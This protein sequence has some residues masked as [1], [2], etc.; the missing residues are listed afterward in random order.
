MPDPLPCSIWKDIILDKYID[1]E[2]LYAGMD[3]GY[4]HDDEPRDFRG[5]YSIVK[6]DHYC[7]NKPIQSE[8]EWIRVARAWRQG[9]ELLYPHR[10]SEFATYME[11]IEELFR[12]APCTPLVAIGVDVEARDRYAKHPYRMDD[13]NSLHPAILAQMFR[14]TSSASANLGKHQD[15]SLSAPNKRPHTVCCNWNLGFCNDSECPYQ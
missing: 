14:A 5:G 1:F 9:V 15:S 7:A 12:A 6:K 13:R 3:R 4:D 11:I 8:S 10:K 2:K